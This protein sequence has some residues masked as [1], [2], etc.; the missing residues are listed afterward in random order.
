MAS[1]VIAEHSSQ[2][3]LVI[4]IMDMIVVIFALPTP[5]GAESDKRWLEELLRG[6]Q[7]GCAAAAEAGINM[8]IW[9]G[10]FNFEP[11][12]VR[13]R[14]DPRS[15]CRR[16]WGRAVEQPDMWLFSP[17]PGADVSDVMVT[18]PE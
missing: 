2:S 9:M 1:H 10:D 5:S 18:L 6:K 4:K 7:A 12:A 11:E 15:L 16:N 13:G 8:I 3:A 14:R 17:C